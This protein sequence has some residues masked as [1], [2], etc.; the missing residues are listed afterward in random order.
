MIDKTFIVSLFTL[1]IADFPSTRVSADTTPQKVILAGHIDNYNPEIPL[2][3]QLFKLGFT[4][5]VLNVE[6]DNKGNFHSTFET[7]IPTNAWVQYKTSFTVVLNPNDSLYVN[8]DGNAEK[9]DL[10]STLQFTGSSAKTNQFVSAFESICWSDNI[11]MDWERNSK[12][13]KEYDSEKYLAFLD[14]IEQ[15]N[16]KLYNKFITE[17]SPD[18]TSKIWAILQLKDRYYSLLSNYIES[19]DLPKKFHNKLLELLPV[20]STMFISTIT[21]NSYPYK[22][23]KY[24]ESKMK[25]NRKEG[26][27]WRFSP[28][29]NFTAPKEVFDSIRIANVI[30]YTPDS[31]LRQIAIVDIIGRT[32]QTQDIHSFEQNETT[33]KQYITLPFLREPLFKKY[34]EIKDRIENPLFNSETEI[35]NCKPL[36]GQQ[37]FENIL[38]SNKRKIIYIDFWATW[39]TPC[40]REFSNS[41]IIHESLKDN[42][43]AFI[44]ICI[45]SEEKSGKATIAE[46]QLSGQ[47]Y[48][49]SKEQ[50]REIKEFF[51]FDGIPFYILIDK[52]GKIKEKGYHLI[53]LEAKPKIEKMFN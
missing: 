41:K 26:D 29:G 3:L 31:I 12:A 20:N 15:E 33:I 4:R 37:I 27:K 7:H 13:M 32:L 30:K 18:E 19:K 25:E 47:H 21:L 38:Q 14:T 48:F 42:N 23:M 51:E 50:S 53:P 35:I 45:D 46:K 9:L 43:I 40:L 17:Y 49:L 44:Y 52:N 10:L 28:E 5:E 36:S 8:F 22:Y 39:C 24:I 16:N 11:Y 34:Y 2:K 6:I 1:I